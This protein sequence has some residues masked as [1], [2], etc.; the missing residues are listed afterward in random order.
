MALAE[1]DHDY[2]QLEA[3]KE[4]EITRLRAERDAA[5]TTLMDV[6]SI[7]HSLSWKPGQPK[8]WRNIKRHVDAWFASEE[9]RGE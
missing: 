1:A 2:R 6:R 9:V 5:R 4:A 3:D 7:L 8:Q